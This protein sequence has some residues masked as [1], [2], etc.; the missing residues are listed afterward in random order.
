MSDESGCG[1]TFQL[2]DPQD[3]SAR[4]TEGSSECAPTTAHSSTRVWFHGTPRPPQIPHNS[5][6]VHMPQQRSEDE[7]A[8]DSTAF[9]HAS[10]LPDVSTSITLSAQPLSSAQLFGTRQ[11]LQPLRFVTAAAHQR[12][13]TRTHT[14]LPLSVRFGTEHPVGS[15]RGA[16]ERT[17]HYTPTPSTSAQAVPVR[18]PT[19]CT[20]PPQRRCLPSPFVASATE[21]QCERP[22]ST[23]PNANTIRGKHRRHP[24]PPTAFVHLRGRVPH[25]AGAAESSYAH[26]LRARPRRP[27]DP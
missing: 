11:K 6:T 24:P 20:S 5:G 22:H 26:S 3:P 8:A 23:S 27:S 4:D 19:C 10:H 13:P 15:G 17:R 18:A 25:E 14:H 1:S 16:Q 12:Y 7:R 2:R 21:H 9:P